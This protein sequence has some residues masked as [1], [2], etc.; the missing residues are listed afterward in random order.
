MSRRRTLA[1][2]TAASVIVVGLAA[3]VALPAAAHWYGGRH[4][5]SGGYATGAEAKGARAS[6]PRWLP[7]GAT[8]VEY[9]MGTTGGQRLLK[10]TLRTPGLPPGCT[11]APG[12]GAGEPELTASWFPKD[13]E[14]RATARCGLYYAYTEGDTL[15][16][17]QR[18]DDWIRN[19]AGQ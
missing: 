16:A 5:E 7:D 12:S 9:A 4:Q 8:S 10:A 18:N 13:A 1:L 19:G 15:Y 17:W 11:G 2:T 3:V 6:V 14:D